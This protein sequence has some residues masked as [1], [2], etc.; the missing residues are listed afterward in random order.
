MHTLPSLPRYA[1]MKDM[2]SALVT[3][4]GVLSTTE[5]NTF[6]SKATARSCLVG[7]ELEGL[8]VLID[9]RMTDHHVD[10]A[11]GHFDLTKHG[12]SA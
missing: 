1:L 6:R 7:P 9:K 4:V 3:R 2:T 8:E 11:T 10:L 12:F 5:K